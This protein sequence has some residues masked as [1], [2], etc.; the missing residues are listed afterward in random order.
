MDNPTKKR[1]LNDTYNKNP[2]DI[3]SKDQQRELNKNQMDKVKTRTEKISNYLGGD[4]VKSSVTLTTENFTTSPDKITNVHIM[5]VK[6]AH[7]AGE[8]KKYAASFR[9]FMENKRVFYG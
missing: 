9:H 1:F 3:I 2:I 4:G 7:N 6:N 8:P 5:S